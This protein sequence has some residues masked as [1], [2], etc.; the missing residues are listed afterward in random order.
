MTQVG[1]KGTAVTIFQMGTLRLR[2]VKSDAAGDLRKGDSN[3]VF[4]LLQSLQPYHI[5][6]TLNAHYKQHELSLLAY[7]LKG[8]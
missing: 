5:C 1:R 8:Q 7:F 6:I 4:C 3:S 2:E